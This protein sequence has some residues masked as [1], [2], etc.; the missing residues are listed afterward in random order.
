VI[1]IIAL[2]IDCLKQ[3]CKDG[4][5]PSYL[6]CEN[7]HRCIDAGEQEITRECVRGLKS[8]IMSKNDTGD[9]NA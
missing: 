1:L 2:T 9:F 4:T 5:A 3:I 7:I 6:D 8:N